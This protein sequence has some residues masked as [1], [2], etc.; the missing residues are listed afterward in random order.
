MRKRFLA[1]FAV[2]CLIVAACFASVPTSADSG[3]APK[4]EAEVTKENILSARFLNMLNHNF[5]YDSDFDC[6]DD[7]VNNSVIALLDMR[8]AQNPEFVADTYVKDYVKDMYGIEIEDM[9]GLNAEY[10]RA[11]GYVYIIPRGFTE[12]DHKI[13]SVTENEDGSFTVCTEVILNPHDEAPEVCKAVTLFVKN[14]ASSF[15]YNIIYSN[16]LDNASNI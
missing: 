5:V 15:G 14:E 7:I 11:E 10:P 4:T 3:T 16:I 2:L 12:Y 9:S 13:L 6:V 8:D 1:M